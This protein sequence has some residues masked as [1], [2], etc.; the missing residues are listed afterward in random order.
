MFVGWTSRIGHGS[1][2]TVLMASWSRRF[3]F[4]VGLSVSCA[5]EPPAKSVDS[6][7]SATQR[8]QGAWRVVSFTPEAALDAPLQSLLQAELGAMSIAFE[9][10]RYTA[11]GPAIQRSGQFKIW[12]A[13]FDM[14]TGTLYDPSGTAYRITG[15]FQGP[16][17][18][19]RSLD[20]PW[21]GQGRLSR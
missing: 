3:F 21:R 13:T 20:T 6:I 7:T 14:L 16:D 15:Q 5:S 9:G 18:V 12:S 10:D 11:T 8:L 4:L 17:F 19:F 1:P 2:S